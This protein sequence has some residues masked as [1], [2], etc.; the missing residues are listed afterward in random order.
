M[1]K[2]WCINNLQ[3]LYSGKVTW[4]ILVMCFDLSWNS[5][6]P[7]NT[8]SWISLAWVL[9]I[10]LLLRFSTSAETGI[11]SP[12]AYPTLGRYTLDVNGPDVQHKHPNVFV[13]LKLAGWIMDCMWLR[14][15]NEFTVIKCFFFLSKVKKPDLS[16]FAC[17]WYLEG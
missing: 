7:R 14:S 8:I 10:V 2:M 11:P 5:Q 16:N 17:S 3:T 1:L 9:F 6:C 12:G 15:T 4:I 13:S